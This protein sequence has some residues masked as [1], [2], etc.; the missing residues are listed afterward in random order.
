MTGIIQS[1]V[2]FIDIPENG[3]G[4]GGGG[5]CVPTE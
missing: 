1:V 3:G 2:V 4:G 5:G